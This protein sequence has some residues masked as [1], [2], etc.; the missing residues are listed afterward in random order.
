MQIVD[1]LELGE[2]Q[3]RG[4]PSVGMACICFSPF[5]ICTYAT[6]AGLLYNP[7]LLVLMPAAQHLKVDAH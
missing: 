6:T 3:R 1:W 2:G 5:F 4:P 7:T